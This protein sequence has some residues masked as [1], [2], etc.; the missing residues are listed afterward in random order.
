MG[1]TA[2]HSAATECDSISRVS[3][4]SMHSSGR[5]ISDIFPLIASK[6]LWLVTKLI[7]L[8]HFRLRD[9]AAWVMA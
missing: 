9:L 4:V 5:H 6:N 2:S 1:F 3:S 8:S 7:S